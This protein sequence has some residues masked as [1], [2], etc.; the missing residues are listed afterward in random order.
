[1]RRMILA[2]LLACLLTAALILKPKNERPTPVSALPFIATASVVEPPKSKT[3]P[4][5]T[6]APPP[7]QVAVA[8][9]PEWAL[10]PQ[11]V[12]GPRR[13]PM[14]AHQ[15]ALVETRTPVPANDPVVAGFARIL[16]QLTARYIEDAPRIAEL[17]ASACEQIRAA[18][19]PASPVEIMEGALQ[20]PRPKGS[21][22]DVPR[23]YWQYIEQ[24]RTLRIKGGKDHKAALSEL[25]P[26]PASSPVTH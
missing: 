18:N 12:Y 7:P 9:P 25:I 3:A 15:L 11:P 6:P 24:Y 4:P 20:W 5:A 13:P 17:T 22:P 10:V 8:P 26:A 14:P 19:H 23:K 2:L 16:S 1:M 21:R